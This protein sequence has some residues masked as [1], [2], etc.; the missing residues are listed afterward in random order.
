VAA[1]PTGRKIAGYEVEAELGQGGMGVVLLASQPSLARRVV[2]KTLRRDLADDETSDERFTREA[3][4]A[5]GV[6]HPNVVVV[7]DCF[8]WRGSRFIAQEHVDGKDLAAVLAQ[9]ERLDPRPAAL[10]ALELARGLEE[11]HAHG[12]VHRDLKPA[13]ILLGRAGEAKIADFG[14]A[15]EAGGSTLTRTGHAV[16]TPAYMS[17]EQLLGAKV[18][19][20]SD[21]FCFGVVLYELLTGTRPFPE[22]TAEGQALVRR[23]EA[24]RFV[25]VR[26]L[27][28][29]TP[30][31]LARLVARCLR[32]KPSRRFAST[33]ALRR[34]LERQL[35]SPSP[36]DCR[37]ELSAWLWER[38]VFKAGRSRTARALRAEPSRGGGRRRRWLAATAAAVA[39]TALGLAWA[40]AALP[41][42]PALP[43]S[44]R[45][46]LAAASGHGAEVPALRAR[47]GQL[48]AVEGGEVGRDGAAEAGRP[49]AATPVKQERME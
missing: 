23:I 34:A 29:A 31:A 11:I 6:H 3:Q 18:D 48:L 10:L 41:G 19:S 38:K 40:R 20:R 46:E 1:D 25:P 22:E 33:A 35:G 5:A 16:G 27:A 47:F 2:L 21:V 43:M 8:A 24:G 12:I 36:S 28:P 26:T 49:V 39:L 15:L 45:S 44:L 4:A 37:Q 9:V 13:N 14:I 42:L 30:R 32:A 7:Y 17:P